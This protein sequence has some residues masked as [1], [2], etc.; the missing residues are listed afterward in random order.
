MQKVEP[1]YEFAIINPRCEYLSNPIGID[2][3]KPGFSW[4]LCADIR[5]IRQIAWRLCVASSLENLLMNNGD[6]WDSGIVNSTRQFQVEYCGKPLSSGVKYYWKVMCQIG[7]DTPCLYSEPAYFETGLYS[8][9]DWTGYWIKNDDNIS[10]P[11]FRKTFNLDC[12]AV[13]A[14]VYIS[15]L[16]YYV[17]Y[18]NGQKV[19]DHVLSPGWTDYDQ[20]DLKDLLYPFDD[21]TSKRVLYNTYD[22]TEYLCQGVNTIGIEL[23]NGWYNQRERTIEGKLWYG[24]PRFI[25]QININCVD[26][27]RISFVSDDTWKTSVGPIV[28]NNIFYGEIYDARLEKSG[29]NSRGFD[30]SGWV[31][32]KE[33][34]RPKGMLR[35]QISPPDKITG[36][37]RPVEL[38]RPKPGMCIYDMG[39]NFSGWVQLK[40]S[41]PEGSEV[42]LRFAEELKEDGT[43]DFSSAGGEE[44]VQCD[45]YIMNGQGIEEYEPRFTWHGFRYVELSGYPGEPCIDTV[46]G[47]IVHS[48]VEK[49]GE[50]CCSSPLINSIYNNYIWTQLSNLHGGVPTDC[51]HRE[52]SGYTGDGQVTAEA[53]IHSFGMASFYT[54]WID[55]IF[56]AQNRVNGF[57]PHTAP[58]SGGGGGPGGWGCA[59]IIL[60]WYMYL[61]YGDRRILEK[62]YKGMKHWIEY[63]QTSADC[64][65]I[66]VKEEPGSW[67]LGDWCAPG[68]IKI[69]R[70]VVNTFYYGYCTRLMEWISQALGVKDDQIF[71]NKLYDAIAKGFNK[72]FFDRDKGIY[73]IGIQ[74]CDV[75]PLALGIV[76]EECREAVLG[77]LLHN[78]LSDNDGHIDTGMFATPLLL[79]VL[80]KNGYGDTAWAIMNKRTYP[81]YGYMLENGAS[82]L[83]ECWENEQGSHN[84]PMFGSVT[85]WFFKYLAGIKADRLNPG[86]EHFKVEPTMIGD[87][88]YVKASLSTIKGKIGVEWHKDIDS[89]TLNVCIPAGST[90]DIYLPAGGLEIVVTESNVTIWGNGA[91]TAY[92]P[93]I[94]SC[95]KK[96]N[97]IIFRVKS[98]IY[99]FCVKYN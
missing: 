97:N 55:D 25:L 62:H 75:F 87:L 61:Y 35:A 6:M 80:T 81:G 42:R 51:P 71:Y 40:V 39:Q 2:T 68:E 44:Q 84:H 16:G 65:G 17:M 88:N 50:F 48:A 56:D 64:D 13:D 52:R 96:D 53:A 26:G 54:K 4:E 27:A 82:T 78:I 15:G 86:F 67:C 59:C 29:W 31:F 41:G 57:I 33:A 63:L 24:T 11:L 70:E 32:A 10:N 12:I 43:L 23:G 36:T 28:F 22:I 77:H 30:E 5:G 21:K 76:P 8:S 93:G 89:F 46:E 37:I 19:S 34:D 18:L 94:S 3:L 9:G 95:L 83:W 74:G 66:I 38:T 79:E 60:P 69:P 98:G 49:T 85:A 45:T 90:A 91:F 58:F 72:R 7:D 99:F 73:S 47:R 92:V 14:R 1:G 20:R